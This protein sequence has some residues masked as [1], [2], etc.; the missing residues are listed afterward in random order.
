M[1]NLK[2]YTVSTGRELR[3]PMRL[4]LP[5]DGRRLRPRAAR[6]LQNSNEPKRPHR[7][8]GGRNGKTGSRDR[9][10]RRR[11]SAA[12]WQ[13]GTIR[14]P[15]TI[16]SAVETGSE[17]RSARGTA[18]FSRA[19]AVFQRSARRALEV[20][21]SLDGL[22]PIEDGLAIAQPDIARRAHECRRR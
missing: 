16:D 1:R 14:S 17:V 6:R 13:R 9:R 8:R 5:Q 10:L 21:P 7:T 19:M 2:A 11:A 4:A 3:S 18:K 22:N 15:G 20:I 12:I